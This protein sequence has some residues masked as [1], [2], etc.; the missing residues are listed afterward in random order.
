MHATVLQSD[1]NRGLGIVGRVV[2]TRGQLPVLA[3]ILIEANKE[4]ITLAATN[5]EIGLR[6]TV[7]GKVKELGA[8]TIPGKNLG[9]LVGS[10]AGESLDLVT[11]GE[12]LRIKSGN[13]TGVLT[14]ISASEFPPIPRAGEQESKRAGVKIDKS[15]LLEIAGQVAYA[16][17]VDESRPVLTGVRIQESGDSLT[18][19]ATD[20]FRLSRKQIPNPKSQM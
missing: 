8:I 9:E 7:G 3:N 15:I 12:K 17:A 18:I 16:A 11:E 20:G 10:L 19:V 4:G 6:V 2:A 5:L 1:L 13:S 14:G